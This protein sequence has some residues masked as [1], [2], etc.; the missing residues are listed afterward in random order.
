MGAGGV[1][2]DQAGEMREERQR[3]GIDTTH[4][5]LIPKFCVFKSFLHCGTNTNTDKFEIIN[6][7]CLTW[8]RASQVVLGVKNP[9]TNA[10]D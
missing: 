2:G 4:L 10:G 8:V 3:E 9:P 1:R 7:V 6:W 5:N